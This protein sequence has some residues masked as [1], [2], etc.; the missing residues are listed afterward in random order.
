MCKLD[1]HLYM[2]IMVIKSI[3]FNFIRKLIQTLINVKHMYL[4][5]SLQKLSV[6]VISSSYVDK[7]LNNTIVTRKAKF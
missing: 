6:I 1:Q 3:V 4:E 5:P 7:T 2:V